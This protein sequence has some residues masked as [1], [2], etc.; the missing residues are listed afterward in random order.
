MGATGSPSTNGSGDYVIAF[1]TNRTGEALLNS[2][3][4]PLFQA[5][6]EATEEAILNSLFMA[7]TIVGRNGN[8]LE[9]IPMDRVLE[10]LR[11]YRVIEASR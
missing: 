2:K 1:S 3:V 9:A 7:T 4:S 6:K 10:I 5:V 8:R 11:K